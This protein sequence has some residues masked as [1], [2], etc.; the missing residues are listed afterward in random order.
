MEV[1]LYYLPPGT[2][3][4]AHLAPALPR[5]RL[6]AETGP[7]GRPGGLLVGGRA[8]PPVW[9]LT[10]AGYHVASQPPL[11]WRALQRLE[12][13]PEACRQPLTLPGGI[14]L[15]APRLLDADGSLH[16]ALIRERLELV[17]GQPRLIRHRRHADLAADLRAAV[18]QAD[19]APEQLTT[20]A[21]YRLAGR[22]LGLHYHLSLTDLAAW[23]VLSDVSVVAILRAGAGA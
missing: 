15:V 22:L 17:H 19:A 8:H 21:L 11:D 1:A 5:I 13:L 10:A 3:E 18:L 2:T 9:Q 4:P 20:T 16:P 23:R 14:E 7:D 12:L 6:R